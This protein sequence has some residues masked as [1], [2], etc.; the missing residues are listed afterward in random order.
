[1]KLSNQSK[2]FPQRV[3]AL[4]AEASALIDAKVAEQR[5]DAPGVPNPSLKNLLLAPYANDVIDAAIAILSTE[6]KQGI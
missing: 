3:Q 4:R 5:I 2:T 6:M 1:M